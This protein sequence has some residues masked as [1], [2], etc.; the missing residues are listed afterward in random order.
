MVERKVPAYALFA[1]IIVGAAALAFVVLGNQEPVACTMEAKLCPDG[2]YVGRTGPNC[3]FAPCPT[4]N[5]T[6]NKII[7]FEGCAAAGYPVLES[8]PRQC[9][10][11]DGRTFISTSEFFA[12]NK[13]MS[14]TT[15]ADCVLADSSLDLRC[16]WKGYCDAINY[17][18]SK[19]VAVNEAWFNSARDRFCPSAFD[20][21][22]APGCATRTVNLNYTAKCEIYRCASWERC[23]GANKCAKVPK[24]I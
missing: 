21:G 16:C 14:C 19:W 10:T 3:E 11:P 17:S 22:P 18:E 8:Y 23:I 4:G 20:C 7:D 1:L 15:D 12:S 5:G 24:Q 13:S 2:S 9:R 6:Q